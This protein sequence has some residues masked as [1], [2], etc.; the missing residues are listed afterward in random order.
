LTL[1]PVPR[2]GD[3]PKNDFRMATEQQLLHHYGSL[4]G[5]APGA[6]RVFYQP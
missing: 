2:F 4:L 3:I 1:I 6:V 5:V